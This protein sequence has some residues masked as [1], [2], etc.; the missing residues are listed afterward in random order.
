MSVRLNQEDLLVAA[1][2][3]TTATNTRV[4]QVAILL[5]TPVSTTASQVQLIGGPFQDALGNPLANGFLIMRLQHDAVALNT[6]QIVGNISIRIPL[7]ANGKIQGTVSGP[8][9]MVWPT[10]TLLPAGIKYRIWA[11][12]SSNRLAWDN[13]QLQSVNSTPNPFNVNA[14]I[15]GP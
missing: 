1:N 13:P 8:A 12:D 14:W 15:P 2:G 9:V 10:D 7:D 5:L 3:L 6:G 11:Y 4:N